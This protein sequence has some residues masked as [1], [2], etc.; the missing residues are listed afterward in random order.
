MMSN[1]DFYH[2]DDLLAGVD[3]IAPGAAVKRITITKGDRSYLAT[4]HGDPEVL[5][6]FGTDAVPTPHTLLACGYDV[7]Q[8]VANRNPSFEVWYLGKRFTA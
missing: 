6:L 2:D 4:F 8:E 5:E 7:A 3:E 1:L